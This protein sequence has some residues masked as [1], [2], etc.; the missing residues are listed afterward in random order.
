MYD[1]GNNTALDGRE[2]ARVSAAVDLLNFRF[3]T[4]KQWLICEEN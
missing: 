4:N 2:K 3:E 1:P